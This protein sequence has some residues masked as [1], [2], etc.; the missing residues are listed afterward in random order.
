MWLYLPEN[1]IA[2][3][4]G[5]LLYRLEH[6]R[7]DAQDDGAAGGVFTSVSRIDPVT[8]LGRS[9]AFGPAGRSP[10]SLRDYV[11]RTYQPS[12]TRPLRGKRR[13]T[14]SLLHERPRSHLQ[15]NTSRR[16]PIPTREAT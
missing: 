5:D 3:Y 7:D 10:S 12:I 4:S 16:R 1:A 11:P 9:A 15:G 13:K 14:R 2:A 6:E 8:Y